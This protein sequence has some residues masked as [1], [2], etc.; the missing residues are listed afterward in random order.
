MR[1]FEVFVEPTNFLP[2]HTFNRI[3]PRLKI[4]TT[5]LRSCI[6]E[7]PIRIARFMGDAVFQLY[8]YG[9]IRFVVF[10]SYKIL[11]TYDMIIRNT[12]R[13]VRISICDR[14]GMYLKG[15]GFVINPPKTQHASIS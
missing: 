3:P 8:R 2:E 14:N 11:G 5:D 15:L 10:E 12:N 4:Q 1:T 13:G 7:V 6:G 9:L